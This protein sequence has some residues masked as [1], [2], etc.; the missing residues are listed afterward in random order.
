MSKS[1][2]VTSTA[3]SWRLSHLRS[4][5]SLA[6]DSWGTGKMKTTLDCTLPS[7]PYH[8]TFRAQADRL[9]EDTLCKM[10]RDHGFPC[11]L[12]ADGMIRVACR[13]HRPLP[14]TCV[15][16]LGCFCHGRGLKWQ[17]DTVK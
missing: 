9:V 10:I 11:R 8:T 3:H 2:I 4:L 13:V 14:P 15:F 5:S 1:R 12:E 6:W 17:I 7:Q 16:G